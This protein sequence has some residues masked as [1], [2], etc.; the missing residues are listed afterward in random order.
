[1]PGGQCHVE[2]GD[3]S[4]GQVSTKIRVVTHNAHFCNLFRAVFAR[5]SCIALD[6]VEF[7]L[8]N[9]DFIGLDMKPSSKINGRREESH[10][11]AA[12]DFVCRGDDAHRNQQF[13]AAA[14]YYRQVFVLA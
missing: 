9:S 3:Y 1:M 2:S 4:D 13:G 5:F 11:V 6:A 8:K 7:L 14:Q 12:N 10:V